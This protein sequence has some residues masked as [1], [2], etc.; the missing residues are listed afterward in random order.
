VDLCLI[1]DLITGF[2]AHV[3]STVHNIRPINIETEII[4]TQLFRPLNISEP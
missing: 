2:S 3:C 4:Y 1:S